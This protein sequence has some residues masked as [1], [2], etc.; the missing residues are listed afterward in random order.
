MLLEN[1]GKN[2]QGHS[3]ANLFRFLRAKRKKLERK[4]ELIPSKFTA[5]LQL[6]EKI[7]LTF[8]KN[9]PSFVDLHL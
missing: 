5:P 2:R 9:R 6:V 7:K 8:G 1:K 4:L 3:D